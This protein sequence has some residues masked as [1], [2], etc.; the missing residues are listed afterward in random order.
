MRQQSPTKLHDFKTGFK[1]QEAISFT[2]LLFLWIFL[3]LSL[4]LFVSVQTRPP[5]LVHNT[6]ESGQY[7]QLKKCT[8]KNQKLKLHQCHIKLMI[9]SGETV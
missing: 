6:S 2:V 5:E 7:R 4:M 8:T 1:K 9:G 3:F